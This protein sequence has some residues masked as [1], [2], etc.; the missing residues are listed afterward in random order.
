M[1][2]N[3]ESSHSAMVYGELIM[4]IIV[5]IL[6]FGAVIFAFMDQYSTHALIEP[7][8]EIQYYQMPQD[9]SLRAVRMQG[10]QQICRNRANHELM[11]EKYMIDC[12]RFQD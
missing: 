2:R 12:Y 10:Y 8:S 5:I 6:F 4:S 11:R 9:N 1:T 7:P 3:Q